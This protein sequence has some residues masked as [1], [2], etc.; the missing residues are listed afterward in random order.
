[1]SVDPGSIPAGRLLDENKTWWRW[2]VLGP[3][4][5]AIKQ[6]RIVLQWLR[7]KWALAWL[8][9][10]ALVSISGGLRAEP[11][12]TK[13]NAFSAQHGEW[14]NDVP[15]AINTGVPDLE[16]LQGHESRHQIYRLLRSRWQA[17][18][19][20]PTTLTDDLQ[21][22]AAYYS[23]FPAVRDLF[24]QLEEYDWQLRYAHQTFTTRVSGSRLRVKSVSVYF[25]PRSAAQFKFHRACSEKRPFCVAS[26][27]D[28]LLHELLHAQSVLSAPEEFLVQGG[29]NTQL[30]PYE[31]ERHTI[32]REQGLYR[33]MTAVDHNPRPLR[34]E[35]SGRHLAVACATCVR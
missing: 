27:A 5:L 20:D 2:R 33:S 25:D 29:M 4:R 14:V 23:R 8:S 1:M 17:E 34:S 16:T 12:D 11:A 30:Y 26:P 3:E 19:A 21:N 15:P 22:M 31:H 13:L 10:F 9:V 6:P 28:V 35:H 7:Q 32:A 24:A 18:A